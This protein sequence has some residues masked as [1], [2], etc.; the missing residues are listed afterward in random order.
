MEASTNSKNLKP[1]TFNIDIAVDL[2]NTNLK[3][4]VEGIRKYK[5]SLIKD[6]DKIENTLIEFHNHLIE[7]VQLK[8]IDPKA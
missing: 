7:Q 3:S 5:E 8:N 4:S 6:V 1:T 2:I